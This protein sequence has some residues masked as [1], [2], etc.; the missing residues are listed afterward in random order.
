MGA[1]G[2][3]QGHG[4]SAPLAPRGFVPGSSERAPNRETRGWETPHCLPYRGLFPRGAAPAVALRRPPGAARLGSQAST[5]RPCRGGGGGRR[6]GLGAATPRGG[7]GPAARPPALLSPSV[8]GPRAHAQSPG[9]SAARGLSFP[10]WLGSLSARLGSE[11]GGRRR[12]E[13]GSGQAGGRKGEERS[14]RSQSG[15]GPELGR[16]ERRRSGSR[17]GQLR[18][19]AAAAAE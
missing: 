1:A 9:C 13:G 12:K 6:R 16:G 4:R 14:E 18:D 2:V 10:G 3:V 17:P 11:G 15:G 7:P 19:A 5:T 8:A